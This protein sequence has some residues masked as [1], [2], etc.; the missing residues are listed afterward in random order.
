MCHCV[1]APLISRQ[2]KEKERCL[3]LSLILFLPHFFRDLI[4][5]FSWRRRRK[6]NERLRKLAIHFVPE[7]EKSAC[8]VHKACVHFIYL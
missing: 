6:K 8:A 2:S 1:R 4:S 7:K 5:R 3:G